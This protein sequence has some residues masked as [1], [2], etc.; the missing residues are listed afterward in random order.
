MLFL[1]RLFANVFLFSY[2]N[3]DIF[4]ESLP[5][6]E[7]KPPEKKKIWEINVD[8]IEFEMRMKRRREERVKLGSGSF[9]SVYKAV[10]RGEPVAVK[11]IDIVDAK[12]KKSTEN[13][14]NIFHKLNHPNIAVF[15]GAYID[16]EDAIGTIVLEL[17]HCTLDSVIHDPGTPVTD[18][19][20]LSYTNQMANGLNYLHSSK[21]RVIHRDFKPANVMLVSGRKK[22]LRIIDFGLAD[23]RMSS[24]A[25]RTRFRGDVGTL[26]YKAPEIFDRKQTQNRKVD[27]YAFGC[28]VNEVYERKR[29][30]AEVSDLIGVPVLVR[31]GKRPQLTSQAPEHLNELIQRCWAQK[32]EQRPDFDS[33]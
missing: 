24:M 29:P 19:D 7:E 14:I 15:F 17:L 2:I 4:L 13:E 9:G 32:A 3:N 1:V 8:E 12:V 10:Y 27:V 31:E 22:L 11:E 23:A 28:T 6:S 21:P 33:I 20:K 16:D 5:S 30:Y 18:D 26:A 25:S